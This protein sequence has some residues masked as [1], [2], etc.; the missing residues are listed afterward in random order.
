M[1]TPLLSTK[2]YIPPVQPELVPR[3]HLIERLNVGLHRKLGLVSAPAGF[4]KTTLL[5]EF[6][7]RCHRPVA[8]LSLDQ[9]DNDPTRFWTYFVAALQTI[10]ADMG[11][12]LLASVRSSQPAAI[13]AFL[14]ALINEITASNSVPFALVLDDFH[15][16][17]DEQ[18]HDG[19]TFLLD[20]LPS[21]MHLIFSGRADPPWPL[22]RLRARGE[23]VELRSDDLRFTQEETAAFLDELMNLDLLPEDISALQERTEGWIAGLQMA[24]LS[25]RGRGDVSG[26]IKAFT[27]SHRFILD[28]LVEEVLDRQSGEVQAFLLRTSILERMTAPLCDALTG[29]DDSQAVLSRLDR[30]NLFI[31]PLDDERRWYRYH[32]LFADLLRGR[33]KQSD[34]GLESALHGRASEWFERQGA[35]GES[36][37]FALA[38]GEFERVARLVTGNALALMEHS[39]LMTVRRQ[40]EALPREAVL[41]RPWLGV[42]AAWVLAFSSRLEAAESLLETAERGLLAQDRRD[43]A[44]QMVGHVA[45]I[46][47]QIASVRGEFERAKVLAGEALNHLPPH[48]LMTRSWALG[49]LAL[50]RYRTGDFAAADKS[51]AAAVATCR[52]TGDS[53][54]TVLTLCTLGILQREQG[55][56][57]SAADSFREALGLAE[58]YTLRVG[59][60][61]PVSAYAH[62]SLATVLHEWN[63]LEAALNHAQTAIQ[64]CQ[65]WGEPELLSA[66]H[67]RLASILDTAGDTDGAQEAIQKGM[68]VGR[69]LSPWYAARMA[70][71]E[72]LLR[73]RRGDLGPVV[74]WMA[75][76]TDQPGTDSSIFEAWLIQFARFW[77]ALGQDRHDDGLAIA[78]RLVDET[79]AAGA[80]R[81]LVGSTALQALALSAR[82]DDQAALAAIQRALYACRTRELCAHLC[83]RRRTNGPTAPP[84]GRAGDSRDLCQQLA[85]G[86]G[87]GNGST[88]RSSSGVDD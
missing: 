64:L 2:L 46:R 47:A 87:K 62:L 73:L 6:T 25:M 63:D 88:R 75:T 5:S 14:T 43:D 52:G 57:H 60:S 35:I 59:R 42:A 31:V 7:A 11:Q 33:L 22:A 20:H 29:R 17:L 21:Q 76:Q 50:N 84:G 54:I 23:M 70:L 49:A 85:G 80:G 82:G 4:G 68:Q 12:A 79:A 74:R 81:Y 27:G 51:L 55:K 58:R 40:L 9:G 71:Q 44:G 3:P 41:S 77:I 53:H 32:H 45:A 36:V 48:D 13:E 37:S 15:M 86:P 69:D 19:I 1:I 65:Q 18:V 56:L 28:Y 39:Q 34:P 24:A 83:R 66:A 30:E 8:W 78:N 61:L 26:F 72:A 16:I 10:R 38:S 67:M